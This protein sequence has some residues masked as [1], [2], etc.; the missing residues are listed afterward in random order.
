[1]AV[2]SHR[3]MPPPPGPPGL[4]GIAG[5]GATT[6]VAL[7]LGQWLMPGFSCR[8]LCTVKRAVDVVSWLGCRGGGPGRR[9]ALFALRRAP[10]RWWWSYLLV[11]WAARG[12]AAGSSGELLSGG[13]API[14]NWG[15]RNVT[16]LLKTSWWHGRAT[17]RKLYALSPTTATLAGAVIFLKTSLWCSSPNLGSG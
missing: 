11:V 17:E 5:V 6:V 16:L 9:S 13:G 14:R 7:T 12:I 3:V 8:G 4:E 1:M 2:G 10:W 15:S